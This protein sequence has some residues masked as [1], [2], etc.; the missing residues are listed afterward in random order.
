MIA[1]FELLVQYCTDVE[2]WGFQMFNCLEWRSYQTE[3]RT[4]CC[5]NSVVSE[6]PT[7]LSWRQYCDYRKKNGF[8]RN[9]EGR[10]FAVFTI[11]KRCISR[12]TFPLTLLAWYMLIMLYIVREKLKCLENLWCQSNVPWKI[13]EK[14]FHCCTCVNFVIISVTLS[15][16]FLISLLYP[17]LVTCRKE[18]RGEW[19]NRSYLPSPLSSLQFNTQVLQ[20]SGY[21]LRPLRGCADKSLTQPGRKQATATKLRIYSTYSPRS[22][23]HFLARC[24]NFCKQLKKKIWMLSAQPGLRGSNDLHVERKWRPFNCFFSPGN[25]W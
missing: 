14:C 12:N 3:R 21:L 10:C 18:G 23:I 7:L 25:R 17:C 19:R 1:S 16:V 2:T 20:G 6:E 22:L 15:L 9:M 11:Y 4:I 24:S 5:I 8:V 13:N